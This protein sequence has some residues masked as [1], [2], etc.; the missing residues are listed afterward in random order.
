MKEA[1]YHDRQAKKATRNSLLI[2][3]L[4]DNGH[5]HPQGRD[6][7]LAT[8]NAE[9]EMGDGSDTDQVGGEE[10]DDDAKDMDGEDVSEVGDGKLSGKKTM[11]AAQWLA[12]APPEV[13]SVVRNALTVERSAKAKLIQRLTANAGQ[14]KGRLVQMLQS[15]PLDE[16]RLLASTLPP[17]QNADPFAQQGSPLFLGAGGGWDQQPTQNALGDNDILP[18]PQTVENLR[19]AK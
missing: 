9:D 5:I 15:K 11:N 8:L 1:R 10:D 14:N 3:S 16:L 18:L 19:D 7:A 12:Q 6:E 13:Q 4:V 17:V 2:Q